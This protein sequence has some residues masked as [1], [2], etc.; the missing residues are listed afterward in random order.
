M[1]YREGAIACAARHL[2]RSATCQQL[3]LA[4]EFPPRAHA[5]RAHFPY[6]FGSK[7]PPAHERSTIMI[8]DIILKVTSYATGY[9][10]QP[11]AIRL[12]EGFV[13]WDG[14]VHDVAEDDPAIADF[15][16]AD[17][18]ERVRDAST[19]DG[20]FTQELE[21][22]GQAR[23]DMAAEDIASRLARVS[24][25]DRVLVFDIQGLFLNVEL[26]YSKCEAVIRDDTRYVDVIDSSGQPYKE[27]VWMG[28][29]WS[30][31]EQDVALGRS[32]ATMELSFE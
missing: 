29:E 15:L 14:W 12:Q 20:S 10:S 31:D 1:S 30:V 7:S 21:W 19:F 18:V 24:P 8:C 22:S 6:A 3:P 23:A 5:T 13:T 32:E 26:R 28:D 16:M 2:T 11:Y 27:G 17:C 9:E 25:D 4:F